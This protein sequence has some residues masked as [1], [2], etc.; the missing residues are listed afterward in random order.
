VKKTYPSSASTSD[1]M[2]QVSYQ[3]SQLQ[4]APKFLLTGYFEQD[5]HAELFKLLI[6]AAFTGLPVAHNWP[7][8]VWGFECNIFEY[9]LRNQEKHFPFAFVGGRVFDDETSASDWLARTTDGKN[10]E[11]LASTIIGSYISP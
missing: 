5:K 6:P 7:H 10:F 3:G 2:A 8:N 1:E 11:K 4:N 9:K